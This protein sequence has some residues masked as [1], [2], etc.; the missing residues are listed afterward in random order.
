MRFDVYR[1]LR[2]DGRLRIER[3]IHTGSVGTNAFSARDRR[4]APRNWDGGRHG[5]CGGNP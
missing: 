2:S 3:C 1:P 4:D 5:A